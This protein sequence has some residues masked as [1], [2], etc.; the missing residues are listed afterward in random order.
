MSLCHFLPTDQ[1][2]KALQRCSEQSQWEKHDDRVTHSTHL[3][4]THWLIHTLSINICTV[5]V[6]HSLRQLEKGF[7]GLYC[8]AADTHHLAWICHLISHWL[9][10]SPHYLFT[11]TDS[12]LMKFN[13]AN[14]IGSNFENWST[15]GAIYQVNTNI[16]SDSR[17]QIRL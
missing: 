2:P 15:I 5:T 7:C 8:P 12:G 14:M 3:H 17:P 10:S 11:Y 6:L 16:C 4:Y 9:S 13:S 1:S